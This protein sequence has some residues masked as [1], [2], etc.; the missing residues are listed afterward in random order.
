MSREA[1]AVRTGSRAPSFPVTQPF[2]GEE[3][4]TRNPLSTTRRGDDTNANTAAKQCVLKGLWTH[5]GR[6]NTIPTTASVSPSA[7]RG[8]QH[9]LHGRAVGESQP[10]WQP[11]SEPQWLGMTGISH[12]GQIRAHQIALQ[13][14]TALM[15]EVVIEQ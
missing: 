1:A 3:K 12:V 8:T 14:G 15:K 6:H 10:C 13:Q 2:G 4:K 7:E 11:K 5:T 9:E